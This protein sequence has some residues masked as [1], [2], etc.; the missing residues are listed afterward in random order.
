MLDEPTNHLDISHQLGL[1]DL[2]RR[3]NLTVVAALHDL[4]H[5]A[6]FCDRIAVMSEGGLVTSGTP[7]EVLTVE[8]LAHVF[9]VTASVERND[10]G[11]LHIR[12]GRS[13]G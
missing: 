2:V 12:Y 10:E 3:Q 4:N 9:S 1:L 13:V 6:M 7:A 8:L 5:A 11:H